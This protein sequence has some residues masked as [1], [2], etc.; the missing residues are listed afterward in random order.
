[1]WIGFKNTI[2]YAQASETNAIKIK[3]ILLNYNLIDG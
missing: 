1:M 3:R 2:H